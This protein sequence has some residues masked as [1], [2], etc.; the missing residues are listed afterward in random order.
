MTSQEYKKLKLPDNPGV[1]FFLKG[2]VILYIGKATSLRSR[3]QSYFSTDPVGKRVSNGAG[4]IN[5]RG[6][7]IVKMVQDTDNIKWQETD[8]VLEALILEADLIKT[9]QPKYNT[10]EKDGKSFLCV[11]ITAEVMPQVLMVRKKD[12]D[13]KNKTAK[14]S[15]AKKT[16]QYTDM[17]GP[18]TN[19]SQLKEA[20][21]IVRRIFPYR[22]DASS[23][24][25]NY[26]FYKQLGLTPE[27]PTEKNSSLQP[28]PS[29]QREGRLSSK[30]FAQ[31]G[32]Q[33]KFSAAVSDRNIF[34]PA[35][36]EAEAKSPLRNGLA[37]PRQRSFQGEET[38]GPFEREL[39]A[40]RLEYKKNIT[41]LKLF[42]QGKKKKIIT[43]L[44][45]E[46][47]SYA[48]VKEFE[49]ANDIKKRIFA[50]THINDIALI[51]NDTTPVYAPQEKSS[52]KVLGSPHVNFSP[53]AKL[54]RP[55][56]FDK[57]FP[58]SPADQAKFSAAV[59]A[60]NIFPSDRLIRIE[61]YDIA[62]LSGKDMVGVMTVINAVAPA[63]RE[64][65]EQFEL[66]KDE[67][68]KFK[69][70]TVQ[71]ANDPAALAEVLTRRFGHATWELPNI[72][73]VDGNEVQKNVAEKIIK[74]K[75]FNIPVVA[76]VKDDKHKARGL[77]GPKDIVTAHK[78]AITLV[79]NEAHRFAIAYHKLKRGKS[80]LK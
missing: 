43:N 7:H 32:D 56:R 61:A 14:V 52:Q 8:S 47:L 34:P 54:V 17:Y 79:N 74:E 53:S 49:K 41:N 73:V 50:L 22:D 67:Y 27:V 44:K 60:R 46:M 3:V 21:K 48:K 9:H 1:Y 69:I 78:Q 19:G 39:L 25:D 42:F 51:K 64:V 10:K 63:Y 80:F 40:K 20:M 66:N 77:I 5:T 62:H 16:V 4:L 31:S 71:G 58:V 12:I 75:G 33:A 6:P 37:E 26:E 35:I 59:S 11:V 65:Q 68:R 38:R 23:K 55:D 57:S 28:L 76:L 72:I 70:K 36:D 2:K 15:R 29:F 13:T 45:K 30:I 18:F 24:R